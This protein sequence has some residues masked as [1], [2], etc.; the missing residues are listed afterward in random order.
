MRLRLLILI[1]LSLPLASAYT[2]PNCDI[3]TTGGNVTLGGNLSNPARNT[4]QCL[5]STYYNFTVN[6]SQTV[7]N[8]TFTYDSN[9]A[10]AYQLYN[11]T[12]GTIMQNSTANYFT[13]NLT[14]N[15]TYQIKKIGNNG[16]TV[17]L[18][19]AVGT[20]AAIGYGLWNRRKIHS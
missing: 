13:A 18:V 11:V 17:Y 3:Q 15:R 12:N 14:G 8:I 2:V 9:T 10:I 1:L 20:L 16:G 6:S 4:T 7:T 5:N 19:S